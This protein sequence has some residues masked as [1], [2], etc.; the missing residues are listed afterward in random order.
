MLQSVVP[1]TLGNGD[2]SIIRTCEK[3]LETDSE[4]ENCNYN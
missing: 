1:N 2:Y 3:L 4:D